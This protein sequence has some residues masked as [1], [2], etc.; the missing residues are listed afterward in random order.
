MAIAR[1]R[2][3]GE[4]VSSGLA[5]VGTRKRKIRHAL[6]ARR[7]VGASTLAEWGSRSS[8]ATGVAN[9]R[10]TRPTRGPAELSLA[11]ELGHTSG[12]CPGSC[13]GQ[14]PVIASPV[15]WTR[16]RSG[17]TASGVRAL[18]RHSVSS[19]SALR[20]ESGQNVPAGGTS[21]GNQG[22]RG[23][24]P[25][26]APSFSRSASAVSGPTVGRVSWPY[27]SCTLAPR[28]VRSLLSPNKWARLMDRCPRVRIK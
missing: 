17:G 23:W 24:V 4:G 26:A 18:A 13:P 12:S 15:S 10:L 21:R 16:V 11:D 3:F 8:A 28:P 20:P 25:P 9:E 19:R 7:E 5:A 2:L 14:P 27:C 1:K 6:L 22:F